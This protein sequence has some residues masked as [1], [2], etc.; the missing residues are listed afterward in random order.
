[1]LMHEENFLV[2]AF[3]VAIKIFFSD[4]KILLL[5]LMVIVIIL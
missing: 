1:M 3:V 5:S 4:S 2:L